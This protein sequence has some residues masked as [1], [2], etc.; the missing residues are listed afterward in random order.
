MLQVTA[1]AKSYGGEMILH[2]VSFVL[3]P[4]QRFGLIGPNG[5]GKSTLLKIIAGI[6]R[7]DG[8]AVRLAPTDRLGYLPQAL[9][10][11]HDPTVGETFAD[12]L[13]PAAHAVTEIERL[14]AAITTVTAHGE[15]YDATM[16]RYA[17]ALDTA[18][19]LDAYTAPAR[20]ASVRAGL[21]LDTVDDTTP[22]RLLSGGQKTRLGL[23]RLLL[24]H[25]DVLLLDEPTNHLD[26]DALTWLATFVRGYPGAALIVSHDRAFL[27]ALVTGI[28]ALDPE[29]HTM[30]AY[31]GTYT[32][33]IAE[34]ERQRQ[35]LRDDYR[36]Q[37]ERITDIRADI[38]AVAG[39][40]T[41]TERGT[42]NDYLRGR[43]KKVAKTA[44]VRERKLEKLLESEDHI[45]KPTQTWHMKLDF[46]PALPTGTRV[47]ALD[48]VTKAFGARTL[49]ADVSAEVRAGERI[50]L[51]GPNGAGKT[52]LLRVIGGALAPDAGSVRLGA[53]VRVGYFAQEQ[54]RLPLD[55][56]PF[57]LIRAAT[58]ISET[59]ARTFLHLFLFAGDAVFAPVHA[60]SYGERARLVLARLVVSG[61]NALLLDEPLNH[62]DIPARQQFESALDQFAGTVLAVAHD[63]YFIARFAR[64]LWALH[65]GHLVMYPDL[66][67]YERAMRGEGNAK[68]AKDAENTKG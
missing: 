55:A 19:R 50:A 38:R 59:D 4:G 30:M 43:S 7:P 51:V 44:K 39:H 60:L 32:D 68:D 14:S 5:A 34:I 25:P 47:L 41:S 53:G 56:T 20:L 27:D 37:Q 64:S 31:P 45:E 61:C 21:A 28:L 17:D 10:L 42:Q 9:D 57:G 63:R 40:A 15:A 16:A 65:D 11:P 67:T 49:F 66:D 58:A 33:Y 3:N 52:T 23:A 1:I 46:G 12:A 24:A 2:N 29:T 35:K 26:L 8:G 36:R 54:E 13:G 48:R 6:E 22:V 62:L 18:D